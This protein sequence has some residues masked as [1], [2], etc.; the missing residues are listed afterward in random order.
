MKIIFNMGYYTEFYIKES[1]H[2]NLSLRVY[3]EEY[4]ILIQNHKNIK[5]NQK[6]FSNIPCKRKKCFCFNSE[7]SF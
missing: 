4:K 5:Q 2:I 6:K 1:I 7:S 3:F